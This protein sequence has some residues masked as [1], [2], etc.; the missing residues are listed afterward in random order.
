[1]VAERSGELE[2]WK[3]DHP[4][5]AMPGEE[6]GHHQNHAEAGTIDSL[7]TLSLFPPVF[8]LY[9][10][11]CTF[12][13]LL[14]KPDDSRDQGS[15]GEAGHRGGLPRQRAVQRR[16]ENGGAASRG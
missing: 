11:L 16:T 5:G 2:A 10:L 14:V 6:P 8:S 12:L 15:P 1:M 3:R 4:P 9:L 7:T 13:Y